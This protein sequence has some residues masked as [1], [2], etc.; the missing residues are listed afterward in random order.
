MVACTLKV[1]SLKSETFFMGSRMRFRIFFFQITNFFL[2]LDG[3]FEK[4]LKGRCLMKMYENIFYTKNFIIEGI[5]SE[6]FFYISFLRFANG[7]GKSTR[8]KTRF[9]SIGI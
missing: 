4:I 2:D 3:I 5:E 6:R 8:S 7:S 9:L 1:L